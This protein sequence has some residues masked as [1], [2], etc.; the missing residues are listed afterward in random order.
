M[1]P[2]LQHLMHI[3]NHYDCR[4]D[5]GSD[6]DRNSA[7]RHHIGADALIV[8]HDKCAEDPQRQRDH[9]HQRAAEME[10]KQRADHRHNDK[11]F[12]KL[13]GQGFD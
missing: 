12:D 2:L 6:G 8:H 3:F 1:P 5:H 13:V 4:I 7:K 9:R 10:Q 11:L